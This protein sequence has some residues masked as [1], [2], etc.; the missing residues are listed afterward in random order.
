MTQSVL[1]NQ[2]MHESSMS[3]TFS[4]GSYSDESVAMDEAINNNKINNLIDPGAYPGGDWAVLPKVAD[5]LVP[6][7]ANGNDSIF[8]N[9]IDADNLYT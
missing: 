9:F 5:E 2:P 1:E 4:N 3:P 8:E 6:Y 7:D